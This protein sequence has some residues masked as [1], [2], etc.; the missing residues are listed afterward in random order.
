MPSQESAS[1]NFTFTSFLNHDGQLS[2]PAFTDDMQFMC[3]Q[4]EVCP[5]TNRQ[6]IQGYVQFRNRT[7]LT[8]IKRRGNIWGTAHIERANGTA[9]ANIKYCSKYT[10][11]IVG[12]YKSFGNAAMAGKPT[13]LTEAIALLQKGSTL[14]EIRIKHPEVYIRHTKNLAKYIEDR[15]SFKVAE[16]RT[17][18]EESLY[19]WQQRIME[20][21]NIKTPLEPPH[22]RR[23]NWIYDPE[24][25]NG[26]SSLIKYIIKKLGP[27]K[28]TLIASSAMERVV[29]AMNQ[30][31]NCQVVL[32][33]LPRDYPMD[34][35]NYASLEIIKDGMGF[36][37]LYH[38][39]HVFW[40]P[41]H[42]VVFSNIWPNEQK[43]TRDRWDITQISQPL[44]T[45]FTQ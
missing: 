23:I 7:R 24:G 28:A 27:K 11:S 15:D 42:I 18:S 25:G 10:G 16:W 34:K 45:I 2:E 21:L 43:L 29:Y 26:K 22:D 44:H 19:P 17:I 6:H 8:H 1:K 33:D 41:P 31:S 12:T 13:D 37:T 32:I 39:G 35:F 5:D 30:N 20:I 40:Q 4:H 14:E 9:E 36:N 3:F 38:P